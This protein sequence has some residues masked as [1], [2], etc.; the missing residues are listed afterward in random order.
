MQRKFKQWILQ[1]IQKVE[2]IPAK[3]LNSLDARDRIINY[4]TQKLSYTS[5][6]NQITKTYFFPYLCKS[7]L[8]LQAKFSSTTKPPPLTVS[9]HD[10][11][12]LFFR[13]F[14][15]CNFS[16]VRS[17]SIKKK[18]ASIEQDIPYH[19]EIINHQKF[20]PSFLPYNIPSRKA[21]KFSRTL[22]K[23]KLFF[24]SHHQISLQ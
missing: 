1:S 19:L 15:I 10:S 23:E 13:T 24:F 18:R 5:T 6:S 4:N 7:K 16:F 12:Q 11:M 21:Q 14:H 2:W 20:S 9:S 17:I 8:P 22:P 3:I